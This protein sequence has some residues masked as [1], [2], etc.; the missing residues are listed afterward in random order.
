MPVT[1]R[2]SSQHVWVCR[3]QTIGMWSQ[4]R[5]LLTGGLFE[6]TVVGL[7]VRAGGL[8]GDCRQ[9]TWDRAE[10]RRVL[11]AINRG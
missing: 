2:V 7:R 10:E 5:V 4:G 8:D 6:V 9:L 1:L 3:S 11:R